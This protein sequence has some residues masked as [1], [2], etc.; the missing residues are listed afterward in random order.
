MRRIEVFEVCIVKKQGDITVGISGKF[1]DAQPLSRGSVRMYSMTVCTRLYFTCETEHQYRSRLDIRYYSVDL[2]MR[3]SKVW[4]TLLYIVC[5][6]YSGL[7][8]TNDLI[9]YRFYI[10]LLCDHLELAAL[11]GPPFPIGIENLIYI[12]CFCYGSSNG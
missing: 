2:F 11:T 4:Y 8:G 7:W 1:D 9:I 3:L 12:K 10:R 6:R 5:T